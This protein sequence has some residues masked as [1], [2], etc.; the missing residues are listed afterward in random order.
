MKKEDTRANKRV[1]K[2]NRWLSGKYAI[3]MICLAEDVFI[4]LAAQYIVNL[5]LNIPLWIKDVGRIL[6]TFKIKK[7]VEVT[8]NG[9]I[10]I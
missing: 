9:K 4:F 10:I 1:M 7:N 6:R 8:D 2:L 3:L 5:V